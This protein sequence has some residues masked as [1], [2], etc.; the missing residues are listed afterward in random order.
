MPGHRRKRYERLQREDR[1]FYAAL[2]W[3]PIHG[4]DIRAV[5]AVEALVRPEAEDENAA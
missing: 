4:L 5:L 3:L 2:I 1:A